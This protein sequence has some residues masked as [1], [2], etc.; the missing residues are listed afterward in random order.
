VRSRAEFGNE[1]GYCGET[2]TVVT[3]GR[4]DGEIVPYQPMPG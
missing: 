2:L 4:G 3:R 1:L